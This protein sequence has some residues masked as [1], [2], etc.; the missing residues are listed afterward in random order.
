MIG[1]I[2]G[3]NCNF[4]KIQKIYE[5]EV[6]NA[7]KLSQV[8]ALNCKNE[9]LIIDNA[10]YLINSIKF[11]GVYKG[12]YSH[13]KLK[14]PVALCVDKDQNIIIGEDTPCNILV[15]D[16]DWKFI[17]GF[18]VC[19]RVTNISFLASDFD[20][21]YV[22]DCKMNKISIFNSNSGEF[23]CCIK[24]DSPTEIK[25]FNEILYVL[26]SGCEKNSI[27]MFNRKNLEAIREMKLDSCDFRGLCIIDAENVLMTTSLVMGSDNGNLIIM[28]EN[29]NI[30]LRQEL[31]HIKR[32]FN[33]LNFVDNNKL[34]VSYDK[35]IKIIK[36]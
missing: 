25:I 6:P 30:L 15:F 12:V 36:F 10:S 35:K 29:G 22:S 34:I 16:Q 19:V 5:I 2:S 33:C 21:L 28:D 7:R 27:F 3:Y 4:R 8:A 14:R 11:N 18:D 24:I 9:L 23:K 20:N 13:Q 26:S 17:R 31:M 32:G 1:T